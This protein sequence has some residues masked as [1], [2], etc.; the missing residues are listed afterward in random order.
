MTTNINYRSKI[1]WKGICRT[2]RQR[3]NINKILN[4]SPKINYALSDSCPKHKFRNHCYL[5]IGICRAKYF[6]KYILKNIL[7]TLKLNIYHS[8]KKLMNSVNFDHL[9]GFFI[10]Q[11]AS[12]FQKSSRN[13]IRAMS[14]GLL[15]NVTSC[16]LNS[17]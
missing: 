12:A 5:Y 15:T 13:K 16:E 3:N 2:L 6:S 9:L 10:S 1:T 8:W 4:N 17:K 7:R 14:C 11:P